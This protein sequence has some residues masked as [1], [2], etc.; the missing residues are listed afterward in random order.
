DQQQVHGSRRVDVVEC[1]EFVVFVDN[2][3][4]DLVPGD[5]TEQAIVAHGDLR[6]GAGHRPDQ[7]RMLP[8]FGGGRFD[9]TASGPAS[10][11]MYRGCGLL[12]RAGGARTIA[13]A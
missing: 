1:E 10:A 2:A 4:G 11:G 3:G 12:A 13:R 8:Y 5:F 6:S 9:L 7:S